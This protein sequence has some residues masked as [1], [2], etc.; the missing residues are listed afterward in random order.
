MNHGDIIE[1]VNKRGSGSMRFS[2]FFILVFIS[3]L[4]CA[5]FGLVAAYSQE[6]AEEEEVVLRDADYVSSE[7]GYGVAY[8][9]GYITLD[10]DEE[11][12]W[13][14]QL[15]GEMHQPSAQ[16]SSEPLPEDVIDTA[17]FW[18]FMKERDAMMSQN[19]T[20]E[21]VDAVAGTGAIQARIENI[22]DGAYILAIIWVFVHDGNG[23]TISAYPTIDGPID[24]ARDLSLD[25]V[26]QFRW[27]TASEIADWEAEEHPFDPGAGQEF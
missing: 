9:E 27:M 21:K 24:E 20:Y 22:Q 5:W 14:V 17:G 6:E 16:I 7:Y 25:L 26:Q 2:R 12:A 8:P 13:V 11:S 1:P 23:Y 15:I 4:F 18:Q 3:Y 10:Y 19:I